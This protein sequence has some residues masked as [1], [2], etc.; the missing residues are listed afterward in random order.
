MTRI[1]IADLRTGTGAVSRAHVRIVSQQTVTDRTPE[2]RSLVQDTTVDVDYRIFEA[3]VFD[4][5][6]SIQLDLSIVEVDTYRRFGIA[7][8]LFGAQDTWI[9]L[10][11]NEP[12]TDHDIQ[13][14]NGSI[15]ATIEVRVVDLY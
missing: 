8:G 4:D 12:L 10:H 11:S 1:A 5:M 9:E 13:L 15:D 2:I 3:P 7:E 14:S 6:T